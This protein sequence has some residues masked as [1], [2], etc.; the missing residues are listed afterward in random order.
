MKV[1]T[2][3]VYRTTNKTFNKRK[4]RYFNLENSFPLLFNL[5]DS[6]VNLNRSKSCH[7]RLLF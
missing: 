1:K 2:N 4:Y 6:S 5:R 7:F 3:E